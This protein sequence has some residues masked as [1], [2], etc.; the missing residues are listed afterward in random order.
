MSPVDP[1]HLPEFKG[2]VLRGGFGTAFKSLTC[3]SRRTDH[4][5]NRSRQA[6]GS[7]IQCMAAAD[8]PYKAIF[9]PSPPEG[10]MRL[11]NLQ[12][13]PRPFVLRSRPD[14]RTVIMPGEHFEWE[15]VLVGNAIKYLPYF[16]VTIK[17]LGE[18]GFGLWY[19]GKRARVDVES[20]VAVNPLSGHSHRV[21]D[22]RTNLADGSNQHIVTGDSI[23]AHAAG[24]AGD[25][26]NI[27]FLSM[28]RLKYEDSFVRV[29]V[30][31]VLVRNILRRL[32]T[33]SYFYQGKDTDLPFIDLVDAAKMVRDENISV[34]WQEWHRYSGRSK[35]TMNFS[36]FV[37]RMRYSG[38]LTPFRPLLLYGS[39]VSVGKG[40]TFGLGHYVVEG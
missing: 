21:F 16:I 9:E 23:E 31:H 26:L 29:P 36:G 12:D 28:T 34:R 22:G 4:A 25:L 1:L 32:S 37:G 6:E 27:E 11:R 30:F 35:A 17:A 19:E 5:H 24:L 2:G 8:C 40:A 7:C 3:F 33:L 38:T 18:S 20:V 10:A 15:M 14:P 13:I 39:I